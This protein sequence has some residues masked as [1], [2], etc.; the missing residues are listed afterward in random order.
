MKMPERDTTA[1]R[2]LRHRNAALLL[3]GSSFVAQGMGAVSGVISARMLGVEGRGQVGLVSALAAFACQLT[4]GGSLPNAIAKQLAAKRVAARDG[5]RQMAPRWAI[6]SVIPAALAAGYLLFLLR[7]G[8]T[9][10]FALAA[11]LVIIAVQAMAYRILIGAVQG[12]GNILR[13][14]VVGMAPPTCFTV[15]LVVAYFVGWD[16]NAL[17]LLGALMVSNVIGLAVGAMMLK[18]PT[19]LPTDKLDKG[20]LWSVTRSTYIGSVGPIDGLGLDRTLVG[21]L[22]GVAQLGLYSAATAVSNLSSVVGSSIA[23]IV[24][25]RVASAHADPALQRRIVRQWVTLAAVLIGG[26]VI[27]LEIIVGPVIRIAFGEEFVG[28]TTCARW[29]LAADGVLGFRRVLIAVLQG[30]GRGGR[31]SVIEFGLTPVIIGG[32]V[33]AGWYHSLVGVS[34][35]MLVVGTLSCAALGMTMRRARG[36]V[37]GSTLTQP[38]DN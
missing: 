1:R 34:M 21:S 28:A 30:Q 20:E 25:P 9:S 11:A 3:V 10:K 23:V 27:V 8:G 31:A 17:D 18:R 7:A 2:Q 15:A 36:L 35:A 5:L 13:L 32:I 22:L 33:I 38:S 24:L 19:G 16:W 14:A 4:F 26:A 37:R 6:G 29:L 12:E